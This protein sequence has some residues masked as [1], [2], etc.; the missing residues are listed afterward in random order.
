[1]QEAYLTDGKWPSVRGIG[2]GQVTARRVAHWP[3]RALPGD[4]QAKGRCSPVPLP[5]H[6]RAARLADEF[7]TGEDRRLAYMPF[8]KE[9][10]SKLHSTT[11][12]ERLNQ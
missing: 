7:E 1:M 6:G 10:C 11:V 8:P 3:L 12:L 5:T 2:A 4:R 9:D